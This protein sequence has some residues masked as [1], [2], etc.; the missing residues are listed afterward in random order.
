MQNSVSDRYSASVLV[1]T[2]NW[3]EALEKVLWGL[4]SQTRRDFEIVLA[5]DGSS[6]ET[7][8]MVSRLARHSPV[9]LTYVWQPDAGFGK[10]RIL[11]KAL[12]LASGHRIIV[13]D[14]DCVVRADFVEC[15][16]NNARVGRFVS[17]SYF[18]LSP[19]LSR[20]IDEEAIK[21]QRAFSV[22]WLLRHG[23]KVDARLFK[24]LGSR[25]P[26]DWV[27]DRLSQARP[28]WNGHSASCLRSDALAVNG[29]NEEMGYGGLDVEFGLRLNHLGLAVRRIRFSTVA[30]HLYHERAYATLEMK[31][32]S[33]SVKE[34]TRRTRIVE[35]P[36][37]VRQWIG[38]A[39]QARLPPEDIVIR[40]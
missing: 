3:P 21:S 25:P 1:S 35:A 4:F 8:A 39:C 22:R 7:R 16:L 19:E 13:T 12:A 5:D 36:L 10:C 26:F 28:T 9:P 6:P 32:R 38:A 2:F 11:N 20:A 31:Q 27:L 17:G 34:N 29:F 14:G 23:L 24:L 18:K 40:F 33:H 37:G 15:H 30:L